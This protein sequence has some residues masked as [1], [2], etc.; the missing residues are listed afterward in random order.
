MAKQ[1]QNSTWLE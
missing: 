1:S